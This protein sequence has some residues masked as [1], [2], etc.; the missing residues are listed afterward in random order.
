[1]KAKKCH[2]CLDE[3]VEEK[4]INLPHLILPQNV[5]GENNEGDKKRQLVR[6]KAARV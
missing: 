5:W 6:K 4:L 2:E 3:T 1:M